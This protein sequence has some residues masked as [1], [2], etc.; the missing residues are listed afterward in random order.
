MP[1]NQ[2][3]PLLNKPAGGKDASKLL[4]ESAKWQIVIDV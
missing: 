2:L 1:L 3:L 4:L